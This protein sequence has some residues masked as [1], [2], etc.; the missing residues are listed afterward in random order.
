[1]FLSDGKQP[2]ASSELKINLQEVRHSDCQWRWD[3]DTMLSQVNESQNSQHSI[4]NTYSDFQPLA[5]IIT[6]RLDNTLKAQSNYYLR[7]ESKKESQEDSTENKAD[8]SLTSLQR[9]GQYKKTN[10]KYSRV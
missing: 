6:E 3:Q 7:G 2:T 9:D 4:G 5:N 8:E 10:K 1:M